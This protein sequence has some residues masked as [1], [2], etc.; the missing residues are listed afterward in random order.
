MAVK[1]ESSAT[2]VHAGLQ[3]DVFPRQVVQA[4]TDPIALAYY[5]FLLSMP[6]EWIVRRS[7]LMDHFT[8]GRTRH[9][10]AMKILR[11]FGLVDTLIKRDE[12]GQIESKELVVHTIPTIGLKTVPM[13][14]IG[15]KTHKSVNPPHGETDHLEIPIL[16]RDTDTSRKTDMYRSLDISKIPSE[17]VGQVKEFIDHRVNKKAPLTQDG[18]SRFMTAAFKAGQ[19]LHLDPNIIIAETI[20]AGWNSVK[21]DWLRNRMRKDSNQGGATRDRRLEDDL[22][23]RSWAK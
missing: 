15:L 21:T 12:H 4:I 6:D 16:L 11:E 13:V 10:R 2:L 1:K 7:H 3:F 14:T 22:N 23:D 18:L 19:D 20:D 5:T 9:D 8:V 17:F